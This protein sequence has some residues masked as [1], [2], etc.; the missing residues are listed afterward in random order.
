MHGRPIDMQQDTWPVFYAPILLCQVPLYCSA[1]QPLLTT[2]CLSRISKK[3]TALLCK[4]FL[5]N[6]IGGFQYK[7]ILKLLDLCCIIIQTGWFVILLTCI[8][9][10]L[11]L[12]ITMCRGLTQFMN[13]LTYC[14]HNFYTYI[15]NISCWG[16]L[17]LSVSIC[18]FHLV[19]LCLSVCSISSFVCHFCE[20]LSL[21][22][23][24]NKNY[25]K[26]II[27]LEYLSVHIA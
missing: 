17:G 8:Y 25:V 20:T 27:V 3:K 21:L 22:N 4:K 23:L 19:Y 5:N 15:I 26:T 24:Y 18:L 12:V 7:Q 6:E 2:E 10:H 1:L 16:Y 14:W 11:L 9:T 13:L